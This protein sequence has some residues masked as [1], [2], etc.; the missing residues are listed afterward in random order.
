MR[1]RVVFAMILTGFVCSAHAG[2]GIEPLAN[3]CNNCHGVN[4]VS[5]GKS[6]PSIGGLPEAYLKNILME[7]KAGTRY[8]ATMGRLIKGYSDEQIAALATYFSKKPWTPAAQKTDAKLVKL[9]K[10]VTK[11]CATCHGDTGVS[12]DKDTPNLNGQW[13]GY[14]ELEAMKYRDDAVGMPNKQMRKA[15]QK[16]SEE[17]VKAV[18]EFYASQ[19]K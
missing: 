16:L 6:M 8:S 14:L 11:R 3:T 19:K 1:Y 9:G 15:A 5:V 18:A 13:A 10:D 4:G 12:E 17:E 7:W 2:D